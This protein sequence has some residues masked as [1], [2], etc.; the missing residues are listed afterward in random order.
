MDCPSWT[1]EL[2]RRGN[3]CFYSTGSW[4]QV[5]ALDA[6]T[7]NRG[8]VMYGDKLYV[9]LRDGRLVALEMKTGR[10]VWSVQTTPIGKPYTISGAARNRPRGGL[11][12]RER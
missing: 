3:P 1:Q 8:L 5:F 11:R 4:S 6:R 9:G 12:L 2:S 7:G 10:P